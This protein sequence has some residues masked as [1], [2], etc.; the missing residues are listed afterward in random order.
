MGSLAVG[1]LVLD[2]AGT[3]LAMHEAAM[4]QRPHVGGVIFFAR[5]YRDPIQFRSLVRAI[6]TV[7][8]ELLLCVDQEGGRVQRFKTGVSRLPAMQVF[9]QRSASSMAEAEQAA[10]ACGWL[11]AAELRALGVDLS[12][13]PVLDLDDHTSRV[14]QS[15]I[16]GLP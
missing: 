9:G 10:N 8:P 13:A 12:F 2:V 14:V 5:N 3:E 4:L 6:R 16:P 11:M 1:P 7:R 15:H